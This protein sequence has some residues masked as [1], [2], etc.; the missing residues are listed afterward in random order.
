MD[1]TFEDEKYYSV[2]SLAEK[3]HIRK[4]FLYEE[5]KT[6]NLKA[7]KFG[8]YRISETEIKRYI[9]QHTA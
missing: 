6:G 3:F 7:T 4:E 5:I 9:E 8:S 2:K 1:N